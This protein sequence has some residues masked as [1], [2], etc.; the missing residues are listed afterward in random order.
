M[1]LRIRC[2]AS[3]Y[4]RTQPFRFHSFSCCRPHSVSN[5]FIIVVFRER[6]FRTQ[7]PCWFPVQRIVPVGHQPNAFRVAEGNGHGVL[8]IFHVPCERSLH[9]ISSASQ[10]SIP[11]S[12]PRYTEPERPLKTALLRLSSRTKLLYQTMSWWNDRPDRPAPPAPP[13]PPP[14]PVNDHA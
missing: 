9:L 10:Q 1:L 12:F 7:G 8:Y 5:T 11:L 14:S 13:P 6:Y 3:I 4:V 2:W